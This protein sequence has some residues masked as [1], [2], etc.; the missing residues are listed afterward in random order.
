[1]RGK[2]PHYGSEVAALFF[3]LQA[4]KFRPVQSIHSKYNLHV[5]ESEGVSPWQMKSSAPR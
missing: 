2:G 1:M 3:I 5:I 4:M